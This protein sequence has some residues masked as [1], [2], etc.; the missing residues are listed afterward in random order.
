MQKLIK[1]CTKNYL[2]IKNTKNNIKIFCKL[3]LKIINKIK[4]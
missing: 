3:I 1:I 4:F 2:T